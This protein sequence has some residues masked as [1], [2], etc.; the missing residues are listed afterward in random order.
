MQGN[1]TKYYSSMVTKANL[2]PVLKELT[3]T[4]GRA[5][6][7]QQ[8]ESKCG[9]GWAGGNSGATGTQKRHGD[10]RKRVSHGDSRTN[11]MF[12][13]LQPQGNATEKV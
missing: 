13:S 2:A 11:K 9:V 1:N 7:N 5:L 6:C 4:Q 8:V 12:V 10:Y 3:L